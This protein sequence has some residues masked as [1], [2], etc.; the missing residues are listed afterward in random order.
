MQEPSSYILL[1]AVKDE[2]A[3]LKTVLASVAA[4]STPPLRWYITDDGSSD[5]SLAIIK[6]F[7]PHYPWIRLIE[8]PR[9]KGR[10]WAAKDRAINASFLRARE[11]LG[12]RFNF[13]GVH[14]GDVGVEKDFYA[15]LLTEG[16]KDE[17]I[18]ILGGIVYECAKGHWQ[19]RPGNSSDS[20]PGTA[21]FRRNA[22]EAVGGYLP[23][24]YGGS[25]W[26]IQVDARRRGF[27]VKI[28][29]A[30]KLYHYRQTEGSTVRGS[31]KAGLMDASLGSDFLFECF[32]CARRMTHFPLG[33]PGLLRLAGYLF[34]RASRRPLLIE[35]ER[36]SYLRSTQRAKLKKL[37][38]YGLN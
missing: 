29:P 37:C 31:F 2:G 15:R 19:A 25:D 20:A 14:D 30:C 9:R 23:L 11:E 12:N 3:H 13:V 32:K 5:D 33:L 27:T 18:G 17:S 36:R 16:A 10:N 38:S 4:Q 7:I 8:N 6:E 26:L 24:A 21:F 35:E 34:Y 28:V 22:F 1:S